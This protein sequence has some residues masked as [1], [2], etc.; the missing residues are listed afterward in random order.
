MQDQTD[1][2]DEDKSDDDKDKLPES[3][4]KPINQM[5]TKYLKLYC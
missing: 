5:K 2:G 4:D 1:H 3:E